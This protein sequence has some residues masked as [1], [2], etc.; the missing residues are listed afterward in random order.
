[1]SELRSTIRIED[2]FT[3]PLENLTKTALKA[4]YAIADL[5]KT[6]V[7]LDEEFDEFNALSNSF[8]L[9]LDKAYRTFENSDTV[10][11][12]KD[13]AYIAKTELLHV[14]KSINNAIKTGSMEVSRLA[15][16]ASKRATPYVDAIMKKTEGVRKTI[17]WN[18]D[19]YS[20][21][22]NTQGF[23]AGTLNFGE[24]YVDR[25]K[26]VAGQYKKQLDEF[27]KYATD[28][29]KRFYAVLHKEFSLLQNSFRVLG[30]KNTAIVYSFQ[31]GEGV[32]KG[33]L[34]LDEKLTAIK[35][36]ITSSKQYQLFQNSR[37]FVG[38][39]QT[40]I[41]YLE[42]FAVK[43][44]WT[45]KDLFATSSKSITELKTKF[46]SFATEG[47]QA[48]TRTAVK[49][50]PKL[51]EVGA[52][53]GGFLNSSLADIAQKLDDLKLTAQIHMADI[54]ANGFANF[55]RK[56]LKNGF[57]SFLDSD[58]G[59]TIKSLGKDLAKTFGIQ[60]LGNVAIKLSDDL[61]KQLIDS[62]NYVISTIDK[63]L[64]EINLSD[65][66]NSMYGL[67]GKVA[68][69]H[70]YR[71]ANELGE[72]STMV[73]E[74]AAKAAYQGIG[75]QDFERIM[76]FADRI[77]KLQMGETTESAASSLI[78]NVKSGHDAGSLAQMLGGGQKME[79]K[80]RRAG[81]ERALNR[82]NLNKALDI[83]EK[84]AK[85]AGLTD[86]KYKEAAD[87]LSQKYK[88]VNN[89]ID[90]VKR[91]LSEIYA[92]CLEP[93]VDKVKEIVES[94]QFQIFVNMLMGAFRTVGTIVSD[95]VVGLIDN[96]KIIAGLFAVGIVA[97]IYMAIR[98]V[99][100]LVEILS[101]A[102]GPIKW[103]IAKLGFEGVLG[104]LTGITK[105]EAAALVKAKALAAVKIIG[106][107]LG[108]T[109][110]IGAM[111]IGLVQC[112]G[113]SEDLCGL[114][115]GARQFWT[116]V[117]ENMFIGIDNLDTLLHIALHKF[118][119]WSLEVT[120]ELRGKIGDFIG[121]LLEALIK[122]VNESP[123]GTLL[124]KLDLDLDGAQ[125]WAS[126]FGEKERKKVQKNI[127]ERYKEIER[128][129]KSMI[130]FVSNWKGV[131]EAFKLTWSDVG[132]DIT[133]WLKKLFDQGEDS[134]ANLNGIGTDT[135]SLVKMGEREEELKWLKAFSDRQIMS[136][137]SNMTSYN[138]NVTFN[139]MSDTSMAEMG[140]RSVSALPSRSRR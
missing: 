128:L 91:K 31:L 50:Q 65:K 16:E 25:A 19:T 121:W 123:L 82:G 70:A 107:F 27:W 18:I 137:Y 48:L 87:T 2:G 109:A 69:V 88:K 77:G 97:K 7:G 68:N 14:T 13:Y 133:N 58:V 33:V 83:A 12:L 129:E 20:K 98:N 32:K 120:Q 117:M 56:N 24:Y 5:T 59:K 135:G 138:R 44:K 51:L 127:D 104:A 134:L 38:T 17:K 81:F 125:K 62:M 41:N 40:L 101:F 106:P 140:R 63:S 29:A 55:I 126:D 130:P 26:T 43:A 93:I 94:E 86:E 35:K 96:I 112:C 85:E 122:F 10:K 102:K 11:K 22:V 108:V 132:N 67:D 23:T 3:E 105:A 92:R 76:R 47:K 95:V 34:A 131:D 118:S 139:G 30:A 21:L 39:P 74:M 115:N 49:M 111:Y 53:I 75:T 42:D 116:N 54:K 110:V 46:L 37:R 80:L 60:L 124:K 1:M 103:I 36:T 136:S 15:A 28:K 61:K 72:N 78:Q 99:K 119:I 64:D 113:V 90:N 4:E 6:L 89:I 79:R 45:I 57:K 114:L 73:G 71:L 66:L 100:N 9:A 84:I 8:D 52:V